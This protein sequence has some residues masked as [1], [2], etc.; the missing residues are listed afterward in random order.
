MKEPN[1]DKI[2]FTPY[3]EREFNKLPFD[4]QRR[5]VEKIKMY[6]SSGMP[7][8]FAK[9]LVN[10]PPATHRFR[11]GK[12]RACFYIQDSSIIIDGIDTRDSAYRRR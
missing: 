7:I 1:I 5:I 8:S 3:G 12:Y 4:V 6:I 10:L 2:E 11:I 9:P